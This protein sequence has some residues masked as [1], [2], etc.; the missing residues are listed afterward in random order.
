M[1]VDY[2]MHLRG[3][4][5]GQGPEPLVLT[6]ENVE[7]WVDM[8]KQRGV[9]EI[10]FTEHDYYFRQTAGIWFLPY[11]LERCLFDLDDYVGAVAEAKR[12]GLPVKL[13]VEVDYVGSRQDEL[14]GILARY[15][16]DFM[17]GSVHEVFEFPV[18]QEPGVWER[19]S[20]EEVWRTYFEQ[21]C[22][23]ANSG[24][25]DVMAHPDLAKIFGHRPSPEVVAELHESVAANLGRAGVAIEIS[26][27]GLRKTVGEIYP[28]E[29]FLA[30]C[31]RHDVPIT[32]ASDAHRPD[33][34]GFELSQAIELAGRVG[35]TTVSVF[36]G[37]SRRQ[38]PLG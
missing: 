14:A 9:D 8:A 15:P 13:G 1:I 27:A 20:V 38:A 28:D 32:I 35:Y 21:L 26:T 29:E 16:F 24:H 19:Y 34:V 22:E 37:R 11:H 5:A 17:L 31:H 3:P 10:G 30:A 36:E 6:V 18:D 7:R 4:V 23:L 2:H 25:V 12:R 33:I